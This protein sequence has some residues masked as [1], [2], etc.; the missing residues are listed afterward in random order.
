MRSAGLKIP[1]KKDEMTIG[2]K[3][4]ERVLNWKKR[5]VKVKAIR[6]ASV[7]ETAFS[8]NR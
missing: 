4:V 5:N 6:R 7:R 8:K 3:V 2:R 1:K